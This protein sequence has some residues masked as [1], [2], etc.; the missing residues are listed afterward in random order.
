MAR[1]QYPGQLITPINIAF[2]TALRVAAK[3]AAVELREAATDLTQGDV[4]DGID[5]TRAA[6]LKAYRSRTTEDTEALGLEAAYLFGLAVGVS[7]GRG[8][9]R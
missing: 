7:L 1:R 2:R 8:G 6:L 5:A 3:T 9:G 4:V